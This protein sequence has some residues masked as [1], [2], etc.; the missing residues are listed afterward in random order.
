MEQNKT[1]KY[2]KYAIGEIV[3]VVIGIL[4]ALQI[5]NWNE[6]RLQL[7]NL[8]IVYQQV[9][10]DLIKDTLN[11]NRIIDLYEEKDIRFEKVLQNQFPKINIDS[12]TI[13]EYSIVDGY[14]CDIANY[15]PYQLQDKGYE[16]L[17]ENK[18]INSIKHDTLSSRIMEF[19]TYYVPI[20]IVDLKNIDE[21]VNEN[22]AYFEQ[23][24]WFIDWIKH[25]YNKEAYIYFSESEVYKKKVARF[26]SLTIRN[27]L[28]RLKRYKTEAKEQIKAIDTY[29]LLK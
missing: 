16:L 11:L 25:R 10:I 15:S 18:Q 14:F 26:Q 17:K 21:K 4:I 13:E 22:V 29:L 1:G 3:L 27:Y 23:F 28:R 24:S 2:L 6:Q 20:L 7:S 19:Y 5:N 9:R 8:K 12:P